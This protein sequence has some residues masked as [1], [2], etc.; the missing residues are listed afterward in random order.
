LRVV[1]ANKQKQNNNQSYWHLEAPH[2]SEKVL[3]QHFKLGRVQ[4]LYLGIA[5]AAGLQLGNHLRASAHL[6]HTHALVT[7]HC[8]TVVLHCIALQCIAQNRE[9]CAR[10]LAQHKIMTHHMALHA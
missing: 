4:R 3:I 8:R 7:Q 9:I 5:L 10:A 6:L 1:F 2:G